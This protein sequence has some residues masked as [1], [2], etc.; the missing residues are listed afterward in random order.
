MDICY[1]VRLNF[2]SDVLPPIFRMTKTSASVQ[3]R[4]TGYKDSHM[5]LPPS[6]EEYTQHIEFVCKELKQLVAE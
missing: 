2:F 5:P 1:Y 4:C 6:A 3:L